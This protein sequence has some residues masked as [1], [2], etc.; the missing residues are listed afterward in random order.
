MSSTFECPFC[1]SRSHIFLTDTWD[2]KTRINTS[3]YQCKQ[4][5]NLFE[6]E[7]STAESGETE[8]DTSQ[9]L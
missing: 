1:Q 8:D 5:L 3:T 9:R 4:C 6:K 2:E 7:W